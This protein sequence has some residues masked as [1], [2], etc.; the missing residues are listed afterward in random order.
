MNAKVP[1]E[2]IADNGSPTVGLYGIAGVYNY[3]CEAI[4]RGTETIL[5]R[6]WPQVRI[7]YASLRPDDDA[8]RLAGCNIEIVP[9]RVYPR[10]TPSRILAKMSSVIGLPWRPFIEDVS[11]VDD[12]DIVFSIGGDIYTLPPNPKSKMIPAYYHP[13]IHFGDMVMEK[14]KK[15]VIW[16]ASIGPFEDNPHAKRVF[17]EHLHRVDLITAREPVTANYLQN[18]GIRH[19]V[20]TCADP[21]FVVQTVN[22]FKRDV[23][24]RIR[25]G[26]N[27]SPLSAVYTYGKAYDSHVISK[28]AEIITNLVRHLKAEVELIPH[29]ICDFNPMDDDLRYLSS[30][31]NILPNEIKDSVSLVNEDAG[32][33]GTKEVLSRCNIVLA[34]RMHCAINAIA[35]GVPT[36]FI[37][38]SS[39]AR[40]MAQYIYG[41]KKW[42]I[43]LEELLFN[44]LV[45]RIEAN[46]GE[47]E[48]IRS[49]LRNRILEI[50]NDA[51]NPVARIREL[52]QN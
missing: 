27:L 23:R 24:E 50:H 42:V 31:Y 35:T 4:V 17:I 52:I 45:K 33:I 16:G 2:F 10:W 28:Q 14:G 49:Y 39:K 5:R 20:E 18:I 3:G 13:L 21:A 47:L 51:Y 11:W 29:V 34:A 6:I 36:I 22:S 25:I 32:F 12:C 38:Y 8:R 46:L 41:D 30:I 40:G 7:K 19:N 1:R 48:S 44:D 26:I 37:A 15:L 43:S 9:R